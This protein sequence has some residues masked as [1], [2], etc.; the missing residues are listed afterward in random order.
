MEG[1]VAL[2]G[3]TIRQ[4]GGLNQALD[5]TGFERRNLSRCESDWGWV[6]RSMHHCLCV[7]LCECVCVCVCMSVRMHIQL[8]GTP[9]KSTG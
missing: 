4:F 7:C 8:G 6:Q 3:E 2:P 1:L 9:S 5:R